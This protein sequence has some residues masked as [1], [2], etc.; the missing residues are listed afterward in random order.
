M[1]KEQDHALRHTADAYCSHHIYMSRM[2]EPA[3]AAVGR[4]N[5]HRILDKQRSEDKTV[6]DVRLAM[7]ASVRCDD[8]L[9]GR[10]PERIDRAGINNCINLQIRVEQSCRNR[11]IISTVNKE[12]S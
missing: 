7:H 5:E 2:A 10:C 8:L 3:A 6:P 9:L 1:G 4:Y 11:S 12:V